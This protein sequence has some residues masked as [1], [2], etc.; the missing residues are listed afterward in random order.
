MCGLSAAVRKAAVAQMD[1]LGQR[2][3][4][5]SAPPVLFSAPRGGAVAALI[6]TKKSEIVPGCGLTLVEQLLQPVVC[7][8]QG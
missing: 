1:K 4:A 5:L 2:R 8:Y 3:A 7:E 6:L